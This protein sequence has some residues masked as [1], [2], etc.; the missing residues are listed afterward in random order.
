MLKPIRKMNKKMKNP[1]VLVNILSN[2]G[3]LIYSKN[4]FVKAQTKLSMRRGPKNFIFFS[5]V[6]CSLLFIGLSIPLINRSVAPNNFYGI[7]IERALENDAM[8][9]E[10][11]VYGGWAMVVAGLVI[12]IGN[13]LL[14]FLGKNLK[15]VA[16]TGI[17]VAILLGSLLVASGITSYYASQF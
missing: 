3:L 12:L 13:L 9:Y 6:I 5:S 16:Y 17:F 14:F 1:K 15:V 11:N 4:T 7:R 10:V 2:F 8:W